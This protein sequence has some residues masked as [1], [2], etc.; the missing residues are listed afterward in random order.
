M[1]ILRVRPNPEQIEL[2]IKLRHLITD[3]PSA[4]QKFVAGITRRLHDL[5]AIQPHDLNMSYGNS[6]GDASC[7]CQ[8]FGGAA[9]IVLTADTLK[10]SFANVTRPASEVVFKAIR[11]GWEFL[12]TEF[13]ENGVAWFSLHSSQDVAASDDATVDTYL[14]QFAHEGAAETAEQE[15]GIRYRPSIRVTFKEHD[16]HWQLPPLGGRVDVPSEWAVCNNEHLHARVGT[17]SARRFG[18]GC[19][20]VARDGGSGGRIAQGRLMMI[21]SIPGNVAQ[22][23][24]ALPPAREHAWPDPFPVGGSLRRARPPTAASAFGPKEENPFRTG[25]DPAAA[26][27]AASVFRA[28]WIRHLKNSMLLIADTLTQPATTWLQDAP[29][30][31]GRDRP[32]SPRGRPARD[33]HENEGRSGEDPAGTGRTNDSADDLPHGRRRT[34]HSLPVARRVGGRVD[35]TEQ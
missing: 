29:G 16:R 22:D 26:E 19:R 24:Y 3:W 27:S 25:V 14:G 21:P 33:Q 4:Q 12:A 6:L 32:G 28:I 34:R 8:L 1:K 13:P 30:G 20:P 23:P 18:A 11:R 5:T 15:A 7:T 35:R 9:S 10:L 2:S 17:R 31:T